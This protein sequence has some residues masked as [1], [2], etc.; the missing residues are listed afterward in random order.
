MSPRFTG[1]PTTIKV[2]KTLPSQHLGDFESKNITIMVYASIYIL[3]KYRI[4]GQLIVHSRTG[5]TST[6]DSSD[7]SLHAKCVC[8]CEHFYDILSWLA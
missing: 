2:N 3:C 4:W 8:V 7:S 6:V 5:D 1:M